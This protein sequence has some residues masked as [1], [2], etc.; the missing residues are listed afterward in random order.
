MRGFFFGRTFYGLGVVWSS[1]FFKACKLIFLWS[2]MWRTYY[3]PYLFFGVAKY[4]CVRS[5]VELGRKIKHTQRLVEPLFNIAVRL[6]NTDY[7]LLAK[8][9]R[10][11]AG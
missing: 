4:R 2:L 10:F 9:H 8:W 5:K 1:L 3:R 6:L 11:T 7:R